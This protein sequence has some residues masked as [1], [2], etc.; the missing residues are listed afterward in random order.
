[1]AEATGDGGSGKTSTQV[2]V[3]VDRD[4]LLRGR[5]EGEERCEYTTCFGPMPVPVS[6]VQEILD[7]A[8]LVGLFHDGTDIRAVIR[9]GRH[10]PAAVKDA[11][12]VRDDFTCS[13]PGCH[14]RARVQIDH[15][16]PYG[17]EHPTTYGNLGLLCS[18]HHAEKTKTD[19]Q[20]TRA[21]KAR[22]AAAQRPPAPGK[23]RDGP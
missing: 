15:T 14:R 13:H 17:Q 11:L 2:N 20:A 3:I 4:A 6:V 22:R 16:L 9:W 8:F 7:D 23:A 18:H 10:V 21:F 5:V 1:M 12:R 19:N